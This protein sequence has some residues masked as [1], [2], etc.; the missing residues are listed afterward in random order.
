M[1]DEPKENTQT[2]SSGGAAPAFDE[3]RM[4]QMIAESVQQA[5][6]TQDKDNYNP[7]IETPVRQERQPT[8]NPLR[9]VIHQ[10]IGGDLQAARLESAVARDASIFYATNPDAIPYM[11]EIENIHQERLR[12][13]I[14]DTHETVWLWYKGKNIDKFIKAAKDSDQVKLDSAKDFADGGAGQRP[15]G[16][17]PAKDAYEASDDELKAFLNNRPF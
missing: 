5:M 9:D 3:A 8:E 16:G 2:P 7:S 1:P 12:A 10:A 4:R 17:G 13:G 11:K 15:I 6:S 14:P